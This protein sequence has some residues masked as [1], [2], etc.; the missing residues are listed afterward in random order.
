MPFA[1][2]HLEKLS[3][4]PDRTKIVY[5]VYGNSQ[6]SGHAVDSLYVSNA[7]FSNRVLIEAGESFGEFNWQADSKSLIYSLYDLQKKNFDFIV[8]NSMRDKGA[9]FQADTNKITIL[10]KDG[11]VTKFDLKSKEEAAKD[12]VSYVSKIMNQ[13]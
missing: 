1:N 10:D 11:N 7:D 4:S 5:L 3:Y 9:G 8:L 13:K 12:I 6:Q 2:L